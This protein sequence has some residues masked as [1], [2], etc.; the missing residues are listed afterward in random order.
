MLVEMLGNVMQQDVKMEAIIAD[1]GTAA[2]FKH[3]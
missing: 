3:P 1:N 2:N